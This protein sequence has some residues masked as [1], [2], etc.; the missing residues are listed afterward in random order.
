MRRTS[1]SWSIRPSGTPGS[2]PASRSTGSS[3]RART[4]STRWRGFP[5]SRSAFTCAGETTTATGSAPAPTRPSRSSSSSGRPITTSS[6]SSTTT[7][8]R[9]PSARSAT[10][11][12]TRW[13]CSAWSRRSSAPWSQR[14]SWPPGSGRRAASSPVNSSRCRRSAA[15]PRQDRATRSARTTRRTS[16]ASWPRSR[17][18]S[19]RRAGDRPARSP[20]LRL[21][22][23]STAAILEVSG[24]VR[25]PAGELRGASAMTAGTGRQASG[26]DDVVDLSRYP[27]NDPAD[28]AYRALVQAGQDQLRDQ[29]VA[30]LTGFLTLAA[31][32][33]ML[34]LA[35][36]LAAQAWASDQAHTVYF[37]PADDSA[38]PDHQ[39]VLLQHS[40][41]Q[42]IAYD[43][44]PA[45][46]AIRR[47]YE[48]DDLTA[49]IAAVLGK[50]VLYRG[51]DPL[52]AVEIAIFGDGDEPGWHF[53][54]SEFSV[55]VMYQQAEAGVIST[56]EATTRYPAGSGPALAR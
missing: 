18:A 46:A 3:A 38:G 2:G 55:T 50:R 36:Q 27:I 32:G 23:Y 30:Q 29:G 28:P 21:P 14:T 22:R 4:C 53:D 12:T 40:A 19:G 48:S 13:S 35:S 7:S 17:T 20:P 54:N 16:C 39:R 5:A 34:T 44:I 51:A 43:Q 42:A 15:S 52:D 10:S 26:Y 11:P 49:F 6:C 45:D 1:A 37:E 41:K 25:C 24:R 33:Q 47:L 31:V 9:A 8:V 56:T